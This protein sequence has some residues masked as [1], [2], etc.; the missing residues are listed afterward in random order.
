MNSVMSDEVIREVVVQ[1]GYALIKTVCGKTYVLNTVLPEWHVDKAVAT[2]GRVMKAFLE[3]ETPRMP[4]EIENYVREV[5]VDPERVTFGEYERRV[6]KQMLE[7]CHRAETLLASMIM[8]SD[9]ED[10]LMA[11]AGLGEIAAQMMGAAAGIE[12]CAR[13]RAVKSGHG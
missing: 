11:S 6:T 3:D 1:R 4:D 2:L 13:R 9:A 10:A 8:T 12:R 5:G 7:T